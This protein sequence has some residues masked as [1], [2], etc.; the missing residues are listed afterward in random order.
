MFTFENLVPTSLFG[1][2]SGNVHLH[3]GPSTDGGLPARPPINIIQDDQTAYAH[4]VWK[5]TGFLIPFYSKSCTY[6][7]RIY[8]ETMGPT[9]VP[10]NPTPVKVNFI[11]VAGQNYSAVIPLKGLA[12]GVHKIVATLLFHAPGGQPTTMAAYEE[13]GYLTV[14]KDN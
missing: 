6:E 5:Q 13:I 7:C 14:Y 12:P 9:E 11:P 1:V 2:V 4:F 3:E 10:A 8:V